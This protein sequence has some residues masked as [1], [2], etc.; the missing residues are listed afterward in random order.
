M[1]RTRA[2]LKHLTLRESLSLSGG[3]KAALL[4]LRK[5]VTEEIWPDVIGEWLNL[6]NGAK[7]CTEWTMSSAWK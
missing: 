3:Q 6:G 5:R 1:S 4:G 7:P 2:S